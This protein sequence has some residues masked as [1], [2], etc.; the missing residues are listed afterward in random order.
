MERMKTQYSGKELKGDQQREFLLRMLY[1]D[2]LGFDVSNYYVLAVNMTQQS[3]LYNKYAGY[4][5]VSLLL[6]ENPD[7]M[8]MVINSYRKE[9]V[10]QSH[11]LSIVAALTSVTRVLN[12]DTITVLKPFIP[13]LLVAEM[14]DS[15][16]I[17]N[18]QPFLIL[19]GHSSAA[20]AHSLFIVFS[21]LLQKKFP[22]LLRLQRP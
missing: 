17:K 2:M 3:N 7:N 8:I 16:S 15:F 9:L 14:F 13:K 12:H 11:Y 22:M 10:D 20:S 19:L 21:S 5:A 18:S 6:H 1:C 4:N